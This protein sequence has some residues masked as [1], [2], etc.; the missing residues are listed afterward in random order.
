[1][2]LLQVRTHA[3]TSCYGRQ[4]LR[5]MTWTTSWS[6]LLVL[7]LLGALCQPT[8]AFL[9]R[10]IST[11]SRMRIKGAS[12]ELGGAET[13]DKNHNVNS[14]KKKGASTTCTD[15]EW[16]A[17]YFDK[18]ERCRSSNNVCP[19]DG[20]RCSADRAYLDHEYGSRLVITEEIK[21]RSIQHQ[22]G[23][24]YSWWGGDLSNSTINKIDPN[25][26]TF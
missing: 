11:N 23:L 10:Q 20:R 2:V 17:C 25:N 12:F 16:L 18:H 9:R 5:E 8:Q 3:R 14:N 22:Q 7:A 21:Q 13:S 6:L 4:I 15:N 19:V 1:M 26:S 24:L